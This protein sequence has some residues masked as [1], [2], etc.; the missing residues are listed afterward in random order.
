MVYGRRECVTFFTF[1][2][3]GIDAQ[4]GLHVWA[5]IC[6]ILT[7][8][9]ANHPDVCQD[10]KFLVD[11]RIKVFFTGTIKACCLYTDVLF[12]FLLFMFVVLFQIYPQSSSVQGHNVEQGKV[13]NN[14]RCFLYPTNTLNCSWSFHTLQKDAQ[15]LVHIRYSYFKYH[16]TH[17]A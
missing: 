10:E 3:T 5:S 12:W 9:E 6:P 7:E 15:L 11:V 1:S 14:F 13:N 2:W 17:I 16:I 4:I 8:T